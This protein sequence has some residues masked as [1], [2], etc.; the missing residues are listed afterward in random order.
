MIGKIKFSKIAI[1]IS[2]TALIW[3]YADLALDEEFSVSNATIV[4]AKSDPSLWVSLSGQSS[5]VISNITLKG[6]ASK[7]SDVK[8]RLKD[9]TLNLEFLLDAGQEGMIEPDEYPLDLVDFTRKSDQIRGFGLTTES[10]EPAK[11]TVNVSQLVEKSLTVQCYDASGNSRAAESIDPP[12]VKIF[13]PD[14]WGREKLTAKVTLTPGEI[15]QARSAVIER[16]PY[17]E[18]GTD[19]RREA[20]RTVKVKMPPQED[21]LSE[22]TISP[23]I[24]YC[25]SENL[26]GKYK[27]EV[28]NLRQVLDIM[29]IRAT[30]E[31]KRAYEQQ[32]LPEMTLYILDGDEKKPQT[33]PPRR[34]VVYNF[35]QEYVRKGEI[36]LKGEP[37][38]A[39]FT[40]TPLAP[41]ET[42]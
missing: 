10:C 11:L 32:P 38:E 4:V 6:P 23:T 22:Y 26:Q 21:P 30:A 8:R 35:P 28:A 40:L 31:A 7:I 20:A 17:I 39:R 19:Q 3:I 33:D 27:V 9:G 24:G 14:D 2:L 25:L 34:R 36:E 42:R 29:V 41:A 1:V 13:V 18:L 12:E 16:T 37:V 15:E 5:A